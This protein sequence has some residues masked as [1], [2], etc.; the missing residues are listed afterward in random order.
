V[1]VDELTNTQPVSEMSTDAS[2]EEAKGSVE[3]GTVP[4]STCVEN[5][6]ENVPDLSLYIINR[7]IVGLTKERHF[8]ESGDMRVVDCLLEV[9]VEKK[10]KEEKQKKVPKREQEKNDKEGKNE[11]EGEK[12]E[13][14]VEKK[15]VKKEMYWHRI[16]DED[17]INRIL[18][19]ALKSS[20][21]ELLA[22]AELDIEYILKNLESTDK[23]A[24]SERINSLDYENAT[25]ELDEALQSLISSVFKNTQ[26]MKEMRAFVF[27]EAD[28]SDDSDDGRY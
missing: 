9:L 13:T 27:G 26:W 5:Q 18:N 4:D 28:D 8:S 3:D 15:T 22:F 11:K 24:A 20:C 23:E 17:E 19:K 1:D 10:K 25:H 14:E 7:D 12:R 2:S 6:T 16:N 21:D